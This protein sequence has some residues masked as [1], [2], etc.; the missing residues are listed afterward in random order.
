MIN[1]LVTK[2][3]QTIFGANINKIYFEHKNKILKEI[4]FLQRMNS[5]DYE[6]YYKI[7]LAI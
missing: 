2:K 7:S 4:N 3:F 5:L 6:T 1:A